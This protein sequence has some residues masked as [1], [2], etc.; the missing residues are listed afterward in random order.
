MSR[1]AD[2][3]NEDG[4]ESVAPRKGRVSRN[5]FGETVEEVFVVA[6]RKGRVSRN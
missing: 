3:I 5:E 2:K 4:L 1:N 6:P